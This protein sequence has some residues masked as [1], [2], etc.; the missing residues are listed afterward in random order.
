[1]KGTPAIYL[2]R[3]VEKK[4]FRAFVYGPNGERK[5][6]ESWDAFEAAM[7]SG[8]WFASKED[9]EE[10]KVLPSEEE[11]AKPKSRSRSKPKGTTR[12]K[13][14]L[15]SDEVDEPKDDLENDTVFE[16]K[17]DDTF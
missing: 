14:Q 3:I 17:G 15:E 16:V 11:D 9:A 2:G 5:L 13:I 6:V 10:S 8:I 12:A 1:M 7:Q 4:N